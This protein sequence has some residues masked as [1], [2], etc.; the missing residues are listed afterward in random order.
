MPSLYLPIP[1]SHLHS[2][3]NSSYIPCWNSVIACEHYTPHTAC[4]SHFFPGY[5]TKQHLIPSP[6][7]RQSALPPQNLLLDAI[8]SEQ[9]PSPL[10]VS[11]NPISFLLLLLIA[12]LLGIPP[13]HLCCAA[14]GVYALSVF[15]E[16]QNGIK[17]FSQL[18]CQWNRSSI[19]RSLSFFFFFFFL[20]LSNF[21]FAFVF[22]SQLNVG[23]PT[24]L[25]ELNPFVINLGSL[26]C[27]RWLK[28]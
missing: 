10:L 19:K 16:N 8:F 9:P 6:S 21:S 11:K 3:S 13:S 1:F 7:S 26:I 5:L 25:P 14:S 20:N 28:T 18:F 15:I 2:T 27:R 23:I 22:R 4:L 12:S 24:W 17:F